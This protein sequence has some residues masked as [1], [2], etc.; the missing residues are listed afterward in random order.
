MIFF[1]PKVLF[2]ALSLERRD[3][4]RL[5]MW[6][7]VDL[8]ASEHSSSWS[9][10]F[11]VLKHLFL[12]LLLCFKFLPLVRLFQVSG[13]IFHSSALLLN[14]LMKEY[15]AVVLEKTASHTQPAYCVSTEST[16]TMSF[17][18]N[19]TLTIS[20]KSVLRLVFESCCCFWGFMFKL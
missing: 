13:S 10:L 17:P 20:W 9:G 2:I 8:I 3:Q 15:S 18:W 11:R 7:S 5:S 12:A 16:W 14:H 19:R 6:S 4:C 1:P